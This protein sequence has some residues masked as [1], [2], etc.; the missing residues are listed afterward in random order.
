MFACRRCSGLLHPSTREGAVDRALARAVRLRRS[1]G[2]DG[3]LLEPFPARPSGMRRKTWLRLFLRSQRDERRGV[4]GMA[5][6]LARMSRQL[7]R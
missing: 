6:A 3:S 5:A 2:G 4:A 1:L 7:N